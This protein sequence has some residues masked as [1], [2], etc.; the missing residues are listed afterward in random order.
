M[1]CLTVCLSVGE[2]GG[3]KNRLK[4]PQNSLGYLYIIA[5][6]FPYFLYGCP[7]GPLQGRSQDL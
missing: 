1:L 2:N 3:Q 5:Y 4:V 6:R 7:Y